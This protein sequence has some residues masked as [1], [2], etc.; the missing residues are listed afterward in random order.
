MR[1]SR[2]RSLVA[3]RPGECKIPLRVLAVSPAMAGLT[4][5]TVP[6]SNCE[7]RDERVDDVVG[8]GPRT[9]AL[10]GRDVVDEDRKADRVLAVDRDV[11][12]ERDDLVERAC[13]GAHATRG[14][15]SVPSP[16]ERAVDA[17]DR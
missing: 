3:R 16:R 15:A 10:P 14:R 6:S 9:R 17:A 4:F 5:F 1:S 11:S 7:I 13:L 8:R 2:L 12:G